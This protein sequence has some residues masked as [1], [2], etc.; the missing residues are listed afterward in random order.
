MILIE[1]LCFLSMVGMAIIPGGF[2]LYACIVGVGM[3]SMS[4]I[5]LVHTIMMRIPGITPTVLAASAALTQGTTN[6]LTFLLPSVVGGL[7]NSLGME[8][9]F[10]ALS[11]VAIPGM[12]GVILLRPSEVNLASDK[13]K[14]D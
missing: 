5:V 3:F 12:I 13:T 2:G 6:I 11:A 1:G 9:A 7:K 14:E 10:L 4:V 8:Y